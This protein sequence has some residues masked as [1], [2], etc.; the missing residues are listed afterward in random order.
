MPSA[1]I[2]AIGIELLLGEI[3]DTNSSYIARNLRDIGVDV[4]RTST[5]G[6]NPERIAIMLRESMARADI[7]I[8][9]G[10]LGPTVDD[11]T[12]DAIALAFGVK[13]VYVPELWDQICARFKRFG[14]VPTVNNKR[15]AFIPDG[16][17]AVENPVGTA[18]SFIMHVLG[19][20]R[21]ISLPGVPS[22]ME[23][24]IQNAVLPYVKRTFSL[25]G[26]IKARVLHTSGAGES[27]ID[28]MIGDLESLANPTVGLAAKSGQVDVRITAKA[29]SEA[30][31]DT[32]IA[33]VEREVRRVLEEFIYGVDDDTLAR[34]A[35]RTLAESGKTLSIVEGGLGGALMREFADAPSVFLGGEMLSER[36][37]AEALAVMTADLRKKRSA[38]VGLGVTLHAGAQKQEIFIAL[39]AETGTSNYTRPYGGPPKNAPVWAVNHALNLLRALP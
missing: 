14:R 35:I 31:A 1:E 36:P 19:G 18:P 24:L 16:A 7:I 33:G 27:I 28:D 34:V 4:F 25:S 30:E 38:S 5:V 3:V 2:I 39:S 13:T 9:T 22:E 37:S 20:A 8:T 6:D 10:G 23:Y 26:I 29:S 17:E 12:R 11:P 15:Q 32:L 21:V